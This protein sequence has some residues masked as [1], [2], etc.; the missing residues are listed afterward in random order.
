MID[1]KLKNLPDLPGVYLFKDSKGNILYIGK[2]NSIKNRIR[3]YLSKEL[4][5]RKRAMM[6][7]VVDLEYFVTASEL[8]ALILEANLIKKERPKFNVILR[9]DKNYPYLRLDMGKQWPRLEVVR[10]IKKDGAYYFGPYVPAGAM[11]ET[12][13]FIRETFPLYTCKRDLSR[14]S[15]PCI[16][17]EMGRCLAPCSGFI[18]KE[19]YHD[20]ADEVRL[21]LQGRNKEL[22]EG[23]EKK[24]ERVSEGLAF[25][26]AARL[27]DRIK[28]LR[29]ILEK[30]RIIYTDLTDLDVIGLAKEGSTVD[31]QILFVR[32]GM[33]FGKKDFLFKNLTTSHSEVLYSFLEQFYTNEILPPKEILVPAEVPS[34]EIIEDWLKEK[35]GSGVYILIPK[36]GRR[37]ELI[38]MAEE[39][40]LTSLREYQLSARGKEEVLLD[41]KERLGLKRIPK[42]IEAFDI[43]NIQG[44]E[45]VG[46]MVA[47]DDNTPKKTDYRHFR[48]RTVEGS[49]DYAMISEVIGRRYKRLLE[50]GGRMPDLIVIDGGKGQLNVAIKILGEIGIRGVDIIGLAKPG[51]S[52]NVDR[53]YIPERPEPIILPPI[54]ASMHLLQRI[55]DESHRFALA[56]HRRLRKKRTALSILDNIPTIGRVRKKALLSHFGSLKKIEEAEVDELIAVPGMNRKAANE[57]Y[58]TLRRSD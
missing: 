28:A 48:I 33:L 34:K 12:L 23:L 29:R 8:E 58:K 9:D 43:S 13:S 39:N 6:K 11:W 10:R 24:M 18:T 37:A 55:R 3:S 50:E 25:E 20:V 40:A 32:N 38:K 47:L 19:K 2:A 15:R 4:D 41:L 26:E 53:V 21:F 1:E 5:D 16:Q 54:S 36:K 42:R 57:L 49:D 22:L 14:P 7:G 45:A 31:I 46:S 52:Y 35:S 27:R 30:Q 44:R 56:Y 17:Y 51:D